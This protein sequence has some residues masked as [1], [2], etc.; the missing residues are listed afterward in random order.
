MKIEIIDGRCSLWEKCSNAQT[1]TCYE[2]TDADE[3]Y[4]PY[5]EET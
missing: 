5:E 4:E 2:A 3:C 1:I